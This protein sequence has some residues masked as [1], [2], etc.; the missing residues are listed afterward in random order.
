MRLRRRRESVLVVRARV[1]G[2]TTE[3][4]VGYALEKLH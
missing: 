4:A 2:P 3:E 1:D